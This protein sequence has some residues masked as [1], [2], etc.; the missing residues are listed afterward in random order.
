M[1]NRASAPPNERYTLPMPA[2]DLQTLR[3]RYLN[4]RVGPYIAWNVVSRTQIW[5]WCA[6]MGDENPAYLGAETATAPPTMLQSWTFRD[7]H[8]KYAPGSTDANTY[9][10]LGKFDELGFFGSVAVSYDQTYHQPLLEGDRIH[11]YSTIVDI[12]DWKD[13]GLGKGSFVTE[14]A[15]YFNQR[16]EL[17]G[18]ARITYLKYQPA[19]QASSEPPTAVKKILRIRP[20]ENHDSAHYWQGLREGK[21]LLQQCSECQTLRHPP[22]PMCESCQSIN[23]TTLEASGAGTV[24]SYTAIHYPEIPPFDYP[25]I[26]VLVDLHEGVRLA[27][28]LIGCKPDDINIGDRVQANIQEVEEGLSLPLFEVIGK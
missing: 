19:K 23:W 18:E 27:S 9:E 8:G 22:Q 21:L 17:C 28:Q 3:D 4:Q 15:E 12:S 7:V 20:V 10:V 11:S 6:A 14:H 2:P 24:H 16:D 1:S 25:N 26:I 13:T 5:Q